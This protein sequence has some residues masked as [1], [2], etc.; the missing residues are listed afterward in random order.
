MA[1]G[2]FPFE[3]VCSEMKS[4]FPLVAEGTEAALGFQPH[5]PGSKAYSWHILVP[6]LQENPHLP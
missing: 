1:F 6:L 3:G 5:M 2:G 4:N